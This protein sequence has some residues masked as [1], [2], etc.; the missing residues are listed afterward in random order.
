MKQYPIFPS[1]INT[2]SYLMLSAVYWAVPVWL[3]GSITVWLYG[4]MTVPFSLC[5]YVK[6]R[7]PSELIS[8]VVPAALA[9]GVP[10]T[11][12]SSMQ[13]GE[14]REMTSC[15]M[16]EKLYTSPRKVPLFSWLG[17]LRISGAVHRRSG[18]G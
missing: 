2:V 12:M 16:M 13:K 9:G 10:A 8:G 5:V 1:V 4:S 7:N 18:P 3:Y 14:Q 17:F 11:G 15:M 6:I